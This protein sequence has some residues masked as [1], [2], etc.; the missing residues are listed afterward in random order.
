MDSAPN[1]CALGCKQTGSDVAERTA[2]P[3][4]SELS[5]KQTEFLRQTVLGTWRYFAE[6]STPEH[7]WL[8]PDNVQEDPAVVAG[9]ISPTNVGLLLNAR[10]VACELGYLTVPDFVQQTQ[11]TLASME[12]MRK[13]RGHLLNWYDTKTLEARPFFVS[14]VDSGNL[15]ASLWTLQQGCLERL[16]LPVVQSH[17]AEGFLDHLRLLGSSQPVLD[18]PRLTSRRKSARL[19]WLRGLL[20]LSGSHFD[21]PVRRVA[22]AD[23]LTAQAQQRLTRIEELISHYMPWLLPEFDPLR[24][25]TNLAALVDVKIFR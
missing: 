10:Q 16:R 13:H 19:N 5:K 2:R 12:K 4:A 6:Y 17:L 3:A 22:D 25:D 7:N 9:R 11:L 18:K 14:S 23:W 24:G 21:H 15:L 20:D 1:H 8:I